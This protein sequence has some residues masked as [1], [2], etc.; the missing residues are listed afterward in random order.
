MSEKAEARGDRTD[1]LGE[2]ER[3]VMRREG[4]IEA[5]RAGWRERCEKEKGGV[6]MHD[7]PYKK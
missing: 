2:R 4:V 6:I 3:S 7:V 5:R 1:A